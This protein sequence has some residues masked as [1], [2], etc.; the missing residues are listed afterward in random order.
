MYSDS[1][2]SSTYSEQTNSSLNTELQHERALREAAEK[3]RDKYLER[4]KLI[5]SELDRTKREL[6][7]LKEEMAKLKEEG[8]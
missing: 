7:Q 6:H 1:R 2:R 8:R 3:D 5:Q 4:Q